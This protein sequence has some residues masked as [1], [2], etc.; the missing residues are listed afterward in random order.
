MKAKLIEIIQNYDHM[1]WNRRAGKFDNYTCNIL[2]F[3]TFSIV[4]FIPVDKFKMSIVVKLNKKPSV[5]VGNIVCDAWNK[6]ILGHN[7]ESNEKE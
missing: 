2:K 7:T 6:Y 4:H 1:S 3:A 5:Y